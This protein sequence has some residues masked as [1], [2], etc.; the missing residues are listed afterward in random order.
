MKTKTKIKDCAKHS[1]DV[2]ETGKTAPDENFIPIREL[3]C[4]D[5]LRTRQ[6]GPCVLPSTRLARKLSE[7]TLL[8]LC[9]VGRIPMRQRIRRSTTIINI[10]WHPSCAYGASQ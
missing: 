9:F 2:K 7:F 8:F 5:A 10:G 4:E 1:G 3:R 6:L